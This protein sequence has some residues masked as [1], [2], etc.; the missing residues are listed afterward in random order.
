MTPHGILE[1]MAEMESLFGEKLFEQFS[2]EAWKLAA[3]MLERAVV[4][5][6]GAATP[7]AEHAQFGSDLFGKRLF[8]LPFH[9]VFYTANA[10]PK[11]AI[12]AYETEEADDYRLFMITFGPVGIQGRDTHMAAP[13][14]TARMRW[15]A[16]HGGWIDWKS[17]TVGQHHHSRKTGR[18]WEDDDYA[19]AIDR[20][21]NFTMGATS[22]LLSKEIATDVVEAPAKV[23][24]ERARKGRLPVRERRVIRVRPEYKAA[25]ALSAEGFGERASPRMHWRRGHFRRV[26]EDMVIPIAPMLINA[27]EAAK[28]LAKKYVVTA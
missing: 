25:H 24:K 26:R 17:C 12:V 15:D 16:E 27:N 23:N 14:L 11:T 7:S 1:S 3:H 22:L 13:L 2:P 18:K 20:V 19:G 10:I 28:P 21:I 9:A 6:Y 5:E 4:F 8:R